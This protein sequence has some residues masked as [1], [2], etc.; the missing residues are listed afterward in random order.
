MLQGNIPDKQKKFL[1]KILPNWFHQYIKRIIHHDQV[2]I[3]LD[4]QVFFNICKLISVTYLINTMCLTK[5]ELCS[6][7]SLSCVWPFAT[8]WTAGFQACLSITNSRN[9]LK[10]MSIES[11][12]PYNYLILCHSLLLPPSIFPRISSVQSSCSVASNSLQS[13]EP[14]HPRPPCP[15]PTPRVQPNSCPFSWWC[16]PTVSSSVV[17]FSSCPQSFAAQGLFQWVSSLHQVA[18]VLEFQ[19]QHQSLQWIFRTDLL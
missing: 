17:P 7:Q 18:K 5:M 3:I 13:H 10:L 15:S 19:L 2:S 9:L 14:Q 6:V 4:M 16:H 12:M 1:N 11:V 8:L